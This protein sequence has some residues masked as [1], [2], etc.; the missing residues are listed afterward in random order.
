MWESII[1][2]SLTS[3]SMRPIGAG[4]FHGALAPVVSSDSMTIAKAKSSAAVAVRTRRHIDRSHVPQIVAVLPMVPGC[5]IVVGD[6][7]VPTPAGSMF[8]IDDQCPQVVRSGEFRALMIRAGRDSVLDAAG[9]AVDRRL[10][11]MVI[12]PVGHGFVIID[13]FRRLALP[14][15]EAALPALLR[16]GIDLLGAG[17]ALAHGE[18]P[19]EQAVV[20]IEH[21]RVWTF[22]RRHLGDPDLNVAAVAHACRLSPRKVRLILT[23]HGGAPARMLRR[24]RVARACELLAARPDKTVAEVAGACGFAGDRHFYRVFRAE[25]GITPAEFR[26]Q[27]VAAAR[28]RGNGAVGVG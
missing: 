10:G 17:I 22:V 8:V 16:A 12:D 15:S 28:I 20:S 13:Y 27:S 3:C 2:T 1:S 19:A 7:S 11:A 6:R 24:L 5:E 23:E 25:T 21:E 26:E 4:P 14:A 18:S 9:I